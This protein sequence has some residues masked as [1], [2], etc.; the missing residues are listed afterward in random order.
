M[1]KKQM[2]TLLHTCIKLYNRYTGY[3]VD[4]NSTGEF[5]KDF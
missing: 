1:E 4:I 2:F 5:D 3:V